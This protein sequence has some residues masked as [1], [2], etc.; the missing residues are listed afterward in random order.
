MFHL[1]SMFILY[2]I[3]GLSVAL[4]QAVSSKLPT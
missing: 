1:G 3:V 4:V 2:V